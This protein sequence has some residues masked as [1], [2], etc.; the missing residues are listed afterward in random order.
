METCQKIETAGP[1]LMKQVY[2]AEWDQLLSHQSMFQDTFFD[3]C[4]ETS[5]VQRGRVD[6]TPISYLGRNVGHSS[7]D[8]QLLNIHQC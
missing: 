4:Q 5:F 6:F 7:S 3:G 8:G 2:E 1:Y